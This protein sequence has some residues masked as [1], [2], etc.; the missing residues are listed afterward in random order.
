VKSVSSNNHSHDQEDRAAT[1]A[2]IRWGLISVARMQ[3]LPVHMGFVVDK[4][5]LGTAFLT[6][7]GF[8]L[9]LSPPPPPIIHLIFHS[10]APAT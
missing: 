5:I 8:L 6:A 9:S 7:L 1:Q 10:H 2:V 4:V 3:T